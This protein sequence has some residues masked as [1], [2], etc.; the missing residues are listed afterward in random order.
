[1]IYSRVYPCIIKR[2]TLGC[3]I[4][5]T[6]SCLYHQ[7]Q[8]CPNVTYQRNKCTR[9][10]WLDQFESNPLVKQVSVHSWDNISLSCSPTRWYCGMY[11]RPNASKLALAALSNEPMVGLKCTDRKR[12]SIKQMVW[13]PLP[14]L[15]L[16][17][18]SLLSSSGPRSDLP[19]TPLLSPSSPNKRKPG[20][21]VL[22]DKSSAIYLLIYCNVYMCH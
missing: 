6:P 16:C 17:P 9:K 1:M 21:T 14:F 2:W 18:F 5:P 12:P 10:T 11:R 8:C 7:S 15:S 3:I 22:S 19:T 4:H 20:N 13:K